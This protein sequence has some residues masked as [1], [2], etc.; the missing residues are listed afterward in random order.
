MLLEEKAKVQSWRMA[1]EGFREKVTT[2]GSLLGVFQVDVVRV[3]GHW[4]SA[5]TTRRFWLKLTEL[6]FL[7]NCPVHGSRPS[8]RT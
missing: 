7:F 2:N 4:C 8:L 1:A 5:I 3:D 6:E